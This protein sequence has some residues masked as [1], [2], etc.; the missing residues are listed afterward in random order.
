MGSILSNSS[1][2]V[3]H[4]SGNPGENYFVPHCV[5][6]SPHGKQDKIYQI[7]TFKNGFEIKAKT[8]EVIKK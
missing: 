2:F 7:L 5:E 3:T 1:P 4:Y 6:Q 8:I